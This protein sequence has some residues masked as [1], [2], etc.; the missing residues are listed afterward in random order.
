MD[1]NLIHINEIINDLDKNKFN[2]DKTIRIFQKNEILKV[3]LDDYIF[4]FI[5]S[6]ENIIYISD[7]LKFNDSEYKKIRIENCLSDYLKKEISL[8]NIIIEKLYVNFKNNNEHELKT[9]YL[10]S[11]EHIFTNM[12]SD[13]MNKF[14]KNIINKLYIENNILYS[15]H[16]SLY[17]NKENGH[18]V[19]LIISKNNKNLKL[20]IYDPNGSRSSYYKYITSFLK[21][22]Q[23]CLELN[24]KNYFEKVDIIDQKTFGN[25]EYNLQYM[26]EYNENFGYCTIFSL[27]FLYCFLIL[28]QKSKSKNIEN[29][30]NDI[31]FYFYEKFSDKKYNH[32][33]IYFF[34]VNFANNIK[35]IFLSKLNDYKDREY[36]L[37]KINMYIFI[38]INSVKNIFDNEQIGKDDILIENIKINNNQNR[39][40]DQELKLLD[41]SNIKEKGENEKCVKDEECISKLCLKNKCT[42]P[43]DN[44]KLDFLTKLEWKEVEEI[45]KIKIFC[46]EKTIEKFQVLNLETKEFFIIAINYLLN[47]KK[48]FPKQFK[49]FLKNKK[50]IVNYKN[51]YLSFEKNIKR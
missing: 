46:K 20:F 27:F 48:K 28:F 51:K 3:Y 22:L 10:E 33:K 29:I 6:M 47:R 16:L 7:D 4:F 23:K 13:Y 21:L 36:I 11:Y 32:K 39:N 50:D 5:Q 15:S 35:D 9:N 26:F 45:E 40:Y 37:E 42:K 30:I 18:S 25:G 1:K 8:E 43:N 34:M 31:Y 24:S 17:Q 12:F 2:Y 41:W 19:I 38:S 44:D 14:C 49:V